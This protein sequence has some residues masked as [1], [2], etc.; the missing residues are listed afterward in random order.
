MEHGLSRR[1]FLKAS[2][3]GT[4]MLG[5]S[6]LSIGE[7][8]SKTERPPNFVVIF[9]DDLGY[10]DVGCFGSPLI[11]TPRLDKMAEEGARFTDFYAAAAVCTPSRAALMTGCYPVR[12]NLPAVLFPT[13]TIGLNPNETTIA[14][15][16][17]TRGYATA[18]IGKWHLG[19]L[20]P[21]LPTSHGFDSYFGIPYS[22][23]MGGMK[24][25]YPN[26]ALMRNENIIEQPADQETLTKR[27][28][29]EAVK[30]IK[31]NKDRPFFLYLPHTFPH[32]PLHASD[33][34]R[35]TSKRGLYGDVVEEIDWSTGQILD[36]LKDLGLDENTLVI[37]TSDNGPW[38]GF[39]HLG[40]CAL[41][42]R[43][44]KGDTF[45]GGMR[46]PCIMRWPG[47]I[48]AGTVCSEPASTMDLL[49]TFARLA[50][51][52]AP[53]DR[54]IDGKN[55]WPL[56]AGVKGAISPHESFFY[57]WKYELHAVRSGKWKLILEHKD[58]KSTKII[59]Q[60]LYDLRADISETTDVSAQYPSVV[61]KLFAMAERMRDDLGDEIT[62]RPGKNRRPVGCV[63][64]PRIK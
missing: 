60:T 17:K 57:Y 24:G 16:L 36:T 30:F 14:S 7:A 5:L 32:V 20:K 50:G 11:S 47:R 64:E 2:L 45:E 15:M 9:C 10:Q 31:K 37:F 19:H 28:T 51:A 59:P 46:E 12:V 29:Q 35:D 34:F 33:Q 62:G 26:A 22:N 54:I 18:C 25:K 55:I 58:T 39:K 41:P 23:D 56:M 21:F 44:G 53:T 42:L 49:P 61:K 43:S 40:G 52:K 63:G 38:L 4:A 8:F 48:P 13:S 6:G 27:Y 3:A 1:Q